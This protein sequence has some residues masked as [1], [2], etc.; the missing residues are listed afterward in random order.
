METHETFM[1]EALMEA[2][3]ALIAGEFPVGCVM[4]HDGKIVSRGRRTNSRPPW[5]ASW[6][7]APPWF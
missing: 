3:K 2:G 5:Q 6:A 4:V 7:A 1:K